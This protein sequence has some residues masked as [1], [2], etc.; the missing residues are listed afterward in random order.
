MKQ[1]HFIQVSVQSKLQRSL[2]Q[3]SQLV[4]SN[5]TQFPVNSYSETLAKALRKLIATVA[6][7]ALVFCGWSQPLPGFQ[8]H[9]VA[10]AQASQPQSKPTRPTNQT[11]QTTSPN[12]PKPNQKGDYSR[13]SHKSWQV[14][15]PD[16]KGLNCRKSP[17][18]LEQIQTAG[19]DID[20]N[21]LSW[22]VV[23]TLKTG[24][25]FEIDL[26]PA[27]LGVIYDGEHYPWFLV[28]KSNGQNTLN[29]CFVRANRYF[30]KPVA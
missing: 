27:G 6:I 29:N 5:S 17:Y 4:I 2:N 18:S 21:I 25:K 16:P 26:G 30:V 11:A 20:L 9:Q 23:G 7:I 28:K 22:P 14:T 13:L 12:L 1:L 3:S 15:D 8:S 24:Q 10:F 19:S